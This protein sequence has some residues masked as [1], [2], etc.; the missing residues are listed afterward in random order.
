MKSTRLVLSVS[1]L[2]AALAAL[3]ATGCSKSLKSA[4]VP[5]QLPTV[6]LSSAPYDTT[7]RYFYSYRI[8]WVGYDPDGRVDHYVYWVDDGKKIPRTLT[9]KNEQIVQFDA[10]RPDTT[11]GTA[12]NRSSDF[13]TFYIVAFDDQG[14][15]CEAVTRSFYSYTV[16]PTV[17]ILSPRPTHLSVAYV[18]PAV[19]ITWTGTDPDGQSTTKPKKYKF[20][21][22]APGGAYPISEAIRDPEAFRRFFAPNFFGWDSSST[23]TT[24]VQYTNLSP[25]TD[26]LFVVVAFDEAGAYSPIFSLDSN[27]LRLRTTFAG[28]NGPVITMFNE[29][30]FYRYPSGG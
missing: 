27:M 13:H 29:F 1:V 10:S 20:K 18:T 2:V 23:D 26:Y 24:T 3:A 15:T 19:R 12:E 7:N 28:S 17:R 16:A 11:G 14:D 21:L 8:N 4:I 6:R 30:F 5:N 22:F 9:T 25:N